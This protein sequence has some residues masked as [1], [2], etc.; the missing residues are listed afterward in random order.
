MVVKKT[1][2]RKYYKRYTAKQRGGARWESCDRIDTLQQRLQSGVKAYIYIHG[3][4]AAESGKEYLTSN[5]ALN[6]NS[7]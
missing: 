2:S 7:C 5:Q 1:L 6:F 4:R 3:L